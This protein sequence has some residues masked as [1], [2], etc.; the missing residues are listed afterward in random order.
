MTD[1]DTTQ[2]EN[3]SATDLKGDNKTNQSHV[4]IQG[5]TIPKARFDEVNGK[6]KVAE[7]ALSDIAASVI[8]SMVPESLRALVPNLPPA[9]KIRWVN[10]AAKAGIFAPQ[11]TS[12]PDAKRPG[13]RPPENFEGL[14]PQ[15]IMSRGYKTK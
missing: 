8:E 6:R 12:G 7:Q 1:Q 14:S 15:T 2:K 11:Q 4:D 13:D 9:D 5:Q 10:D 3:G